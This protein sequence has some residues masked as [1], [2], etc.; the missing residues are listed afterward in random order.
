MQVRGPNVKLINLIIKADVQG[1]METLIKTVTEAN[2]D[3]AKVQVADAML[4][5]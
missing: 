4:V 3:E 1:S 2:T 5:H